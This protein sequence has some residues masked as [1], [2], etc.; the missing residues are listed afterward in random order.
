MEPTNENYLV[1][2]MQARQK[3]KSVHEFFLDKG[4]IKQPL[5]EFWEDEEDAA[6]VSHSVS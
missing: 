4:I 2:S 5:D 1:R 3:K 6:L